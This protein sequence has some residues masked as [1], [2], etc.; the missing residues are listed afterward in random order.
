MANST[1]SFAVQSVTPV[2]DKTVTLVYSK[3]DGD[4][5]ET[6][7]STIIYT[8]AAPGW[9]FVGI[10]PTSGNG[11]DI[12]PNVSSDGLTLTLNDA[13]T[14]IGTFSFLI[15]VSS[16]SATYNSQDPQVINKPPQ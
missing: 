2:N 10:V 16:G 12:T 11:T 13:D 14:I 4:A 7:P 8:M 15:Q 1:T 3:S 5:V 6:A 9:A